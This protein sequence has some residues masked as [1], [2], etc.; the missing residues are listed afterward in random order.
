MVSKPLRFFS[1]KGSSR[2][3]LLFIYLYMT[4]VNNLCLLNKC[5]SCIQLCCTVCMPVLRICQGCFMLFLGRLG[6]L[7]DSK[8]YDFSLSQLPS[9]KN[10]PIVHFH[11]YTSLISHGVVRWLMHQWCNQS[12]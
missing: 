6:R 7:K 10:F 8:R 1:Y 12:Q 9:P 3:T 2:C 4:S 11:F 5:Y